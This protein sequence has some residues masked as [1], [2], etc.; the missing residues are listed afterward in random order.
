MILLVVGCLRIFILLL[1]LSFLLRLAYIHLLLIQLLHGGE[2]TQ[3]VLAPKDTVE[4][5]ASRCRNME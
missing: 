5:I 2:Q 4:H 1:F 3:M